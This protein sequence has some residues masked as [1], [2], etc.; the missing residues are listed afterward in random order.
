MRFT[1]Q[2]AP[3]GVY[4]FLSES[5]QK[6]GAHLLNDIKFLNVS[7]CKEFLKNIISSTKYNS[8]Y[9]LNLVL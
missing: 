6:E 1:R 3:T 5:T 9:R 2:Q 7:Y 8:F 4:V